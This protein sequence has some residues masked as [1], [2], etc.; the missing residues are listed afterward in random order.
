[1]TPLRLK[2]GPQWK[3]QVRTRQQR[4]IVGYCGQFEINTG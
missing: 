2:E 1:M 3:S 4:G